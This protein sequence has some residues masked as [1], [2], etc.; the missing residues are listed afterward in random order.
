VANLII[1]ISKN[2]EE[3]PRNP[4][5][6]LVYFSF[7]EKK[8]SPSC[9]NSPTKKK[10]KTLFRTHWE[11]EANIGGNPAPPVTR[12]SPKV[13]VVN[14]IQVKVGVKNLELAMA[15]AAA[16]SDEEEEEEEEDE[17]LLACLVSPCELHCSSSHCGQRNFARA[18]RF[19]KLQIGVLFE[20]SKKKSLF[21][22]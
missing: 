19:S 6:F 16:S 5:N 10:K 22:R 1:F 20:G 14:A 21:F 4:R 8:N 12:E 15:M 17:A 18:F 7:S 13:T 3:I 9:E 11:R 2:G